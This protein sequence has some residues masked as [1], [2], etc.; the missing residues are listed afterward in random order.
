MNILEK[1]LNIL[2]KQQTLMLFKMYNF[3]K[4]IIFL[5][6]KWKL[7]DDLF[8]FLMEKGLDEE[9]I[10]FCQVHGKENH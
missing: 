9:M 5:L 4:G 2:D 8:Q 6:E 10:E 7:L 3:D 1:S